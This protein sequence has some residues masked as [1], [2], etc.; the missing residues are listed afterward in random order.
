MQIMNLHS[1]SLL[2]QGVGISQRAYIWTQTTAWRRPEGRGDEGWA[3][4]GKRDICNS[5][6]NQS[7]EKDIVFY[8][9][10][11]LMSCMFTG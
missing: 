5:V 2:K 11:L 10:L 8:Y 1:F 4:G 9:S 6:N 7:K 3:E